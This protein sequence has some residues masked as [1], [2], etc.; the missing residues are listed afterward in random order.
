[1]ILKNSDTFNFLLKSLV[2][3]TFKSSSI[4]ISFMYTP[5]KYFLLLNDCVLKAIKC[6]NNIISINTI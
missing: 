6:V 5:K 3:L 1:M 2:I 4:I